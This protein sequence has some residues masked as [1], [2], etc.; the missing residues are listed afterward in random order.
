MVVGGL[1]TGI[2]P[3][4]HM[5]ETASICL[6]LAAMFATWF[7]V[8]FV[9]LVRGLHTNPK[10]EVARLHKKRKIEKAGFGY[11]A[12]LSRGLPRAGERRD[13]GTLESDSHETMRD[14][15]ILGQTSEDGTDGVNRSD[16][17]SRGPIE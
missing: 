5:L 10:R 11:A 8:H 7:I 1:F 6:V 4:S 12:Q 13:S 2:T 15:D 9:L 3:E 14:I 16:D 17:P